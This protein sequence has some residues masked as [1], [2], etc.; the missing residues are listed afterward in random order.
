MTFYIWLFFCCFFRPTAV[1]W[2]VPIF[3]PMMLQHDTCPVCRMSLNGEDSSSQPSSESPSLSTDP[4]T[5]ERWSFWDT[6][7]SHSL[8][9]VNYIQQ[10]KKTCYSFSTFSL[11]SLLDNLSLFVYLFSIFNAFFFSHVPS[12]R[13]LNLLWFAKAII[14]PIDQPRLTLLLPCIIIFSSQTANFSSYT[15]LQHSAG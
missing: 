9:S 4:R 1:I 7:L 5:Q 13:R 6:Q 14:C 15:L 8:L 2:H 11:C 10:Q 3:F 12:L